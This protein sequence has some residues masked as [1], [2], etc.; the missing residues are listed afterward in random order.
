MRFFTKC[1]I[2]KK[3]KFF[4]DIIIGES[5]CIECCDKMFKKMQLE[6]KN[7]LI[8]KCPLCKQNM[9]LIENVVS[10]YYGV[11]VCENENCHGYGIERKVD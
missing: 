3:K 7:S 4:M 8:K 11:Q 1:S 6:Y 5:Y 10:G 2:C 9:C